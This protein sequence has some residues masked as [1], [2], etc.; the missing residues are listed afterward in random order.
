M[1]KILNPVGMIT[2]GGEG[3]GQA[4]FDKRQSLALGLCKALLEKKT[5]Y[6]ECGNRNLEDC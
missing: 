6:N 2:A 3:I 5:V 4:P 1:T